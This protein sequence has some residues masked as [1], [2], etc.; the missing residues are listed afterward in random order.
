MA[1]RPSRRFSTRARA[2]ARA[3]TWASTTSRPPVEIAEVCT[4]RWPHSM[5]ELA[6]RPDEAQRAA[7]AACISRTGRRTSCRWSPPASADDPD[8]RQ[9]PRR[10]SRRCIEETW[11]LSPYGHIRHSL[12]GGFYQGWDLH[13]A[14]LPVRYAACFAFFLEGFAPAAE[15]ACRK[16]ASNGG[17]RGEGPSAI[18]DEPATVQALTELRA[19][20]ARLRSRGRKRPQKRRACRATSTRRA[21]AAWLTAAAQ[22]RAAQ[23]A[24]R[25]APL[26]TPGLSL[27]SPE[28]N[29]VRRGKGRDV[30]KLKPSGRR[31][32]PILAFAA[33]AGT[34]SADSAAA[35]P[36]TRAARRRRTDKLWAAQQCA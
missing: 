35:Q 36:V 24:E 27:C 10:T 20:R 2:G 14:Q 11:R 4:S 28:N 12:E 17:Q 18:A 3:S 29:L 19:A 21:L 23:N 34:A 32:P 31:W 8:S 16:F 5:C 30:K 22:R 13:P 6:A 33:W 15:A 25:S 9:R 1:D 7:V 26:E